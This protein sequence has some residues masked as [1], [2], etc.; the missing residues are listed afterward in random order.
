FQVSAQDEVD[1]SVDVS[2]DH[3]SGE[4]FPIGKTVVA[5]TAKDT[6]GNS[7]EKSFIITVQDTTAPNVQITKAVDKKAVEIAEGS[8]TKSHYIKLTFTQTDAVGVKNTQC[9]LDGQAFTSCTS[10]IIYDQLKKGTHTVTVR[11]QMQG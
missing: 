3:K 10:P 7:A 6:A 11:A 1:G 4:T 8:V 5:C 9:S 2:C